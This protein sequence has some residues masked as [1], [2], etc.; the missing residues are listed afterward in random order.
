MYISGCSL[1]L[2]MAA[3]PIKILPV[4]T[5]NIG[6]GVLANIILRNT[7]PPGAPQRIDMA[8]I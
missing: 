8:E 2:S 3:F 5:S 4:T 1:Y 7:L 6:Q